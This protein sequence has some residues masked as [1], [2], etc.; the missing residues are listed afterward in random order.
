MI[1]PE[2]API[3]AERFED[4]SDGD[5]LVLPMMARFADCTFSHRIKRIMDLIGVERWPRFFHSMR[6]TRQTELEEVWP[7]HVVCYWLG[8]STEIARRHYLMTTDEDFTKAAHNPTQHAPAQGG[9]ETKPNV[10]TIEKT[11]VLQGRAAS[12][13]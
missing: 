9:M 8:N 5:E 2:I 3:L 10:A 1:F 11:P 6:A 7:S 4:A 13:D 12:C